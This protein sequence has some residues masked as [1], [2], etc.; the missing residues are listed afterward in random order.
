[1]NTGAGWVA[2]GPD[3]RYPTSFAQSMD[4]DVGQGEMG[5]PFVHALALKSGGGLSHAAGSRFADINSDRLLD[6]V[7]DRLFEEAGDAAGGL[8]QVLL[9]NG[10][11]WV[12]DTGTDIEY[13]SF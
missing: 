10:C 11:E 12:V 3:F 8:S 2:E 6:R 9:K 7:F 5:L 13:C 4:A 1:M